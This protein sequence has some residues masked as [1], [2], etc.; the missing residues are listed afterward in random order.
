V[1][2]PLVREFSTGAGLANPWVLS[3][4]LILC[5]ITVPATDSNNH[6]VNGPGNGSEIIKCIYNHKASGPGTYSSD[7]SLRS[8][9]GTGTH[10]KESSFCSLDSGAGAHNHGFF[11]SSCAG[12]CTDCNKLQLRYVNS[13]DTYISERCFSLGS[14]R[15]GTGTG[16]HGKKFLIFSL[17]SGTGTHNH[18]FF[19]SSC[20]GASTECNNLQYR[21]VNITGTYITELCFDLGTSTGTHIQKL[22]CS[23]SVLDL[24]SCSSSGTCTGTNKKK[25]VFSLDSVNSALNSIIFFSC[26]SGACIYINKVQY[27]YANSSD[28]VTLVFPFSLGTGTGT[29]KQTFLFSSPAHNHRIFFSSGIG[30][31]DGAGTH[32]NKSRYQDINS[33]NTYILEVY[34]SLDTGTCMYIKKFF[35]S[36]EMGTV[37]NINI[38]LFSSCTGNGTH[39]H[40]FFFSYGNGTVTGAYSHINNL[41]YRY[42]NNSY[43]YKFVILS[44]SGTNTGTNLRIFFFSSDRDID[45]HISIVLFSSDTGTGAS[46]ETLILLTIHLYVSLSLL[47]HHFSFFYCLEMADTSAHLTD[48]DGETMEDDKGKVDETIL[49][50]EEEEQQDSIAPGQQEPMETTPPAT[51]ADG[52]ISGTPPAAATTVKP[53]GT[54]ASTDAT[55][56]G[57]NNTSTNNEP[58][59]VTDDKSRRGSEGSSSFATCNSGDNIMPRIYYNIRSAKLSKISVR[60]LSDCAEHN[61]VHIGSFEE[62]DSTDRA[63]IAN[64][65]HS[66][67]KLQNISSS[68]TLDTLECRSC[69]KGGH[70]VLHRESKTVDGRN[71][72]PQVFVL[73]DQNFP[74]AL[75]V[76]EDGECVKV[77]R[78]ENGSLHE[79]V[80]SFL[81][82]TKG[83]M[84]PAGTVVL[85]SSASLL[86]EVGVN[87]YVGRYL[88]ARNV[89]LGAFKGGLEVVHGLPIL[90]SG[91]SDRA[92]IRAL[93]DITDW[94]ASGPGTS[95]RDITDTRT[96]YKA[97]VLGTLA[98][99]GSPEASASTAGSSETPASGSG[100]PAAP[101]PIRYFLPT[102]LTGSKKMSFVSKPDNVPVIIV[103]IECDT[104]EL[105]LNTL[106]NELNAKFLADLAPLAVAE[107]DQDRGPVDPVPDIIA[108]G[109]KRFII[110]GGSHAARLAECLDNVGLHVA[111][112]SIPGWTVTDANVDSMLALLEKVLAEKSDKNSVIIYQLFDNDSYFGTNTDGSCLKPFKQGGKYHIQGDLQMADRDQLKVLVGRATPLLRAGGEADKIVLVP[113][114]RYVTAKCCSN[115]AH[116]TNFNDDS[117]GDLHANRLTEMRKWLGDICFFKRIRNFRV[118]C[119]NELLHECAGKAVQS[120]WAG[121]P[122]HMNNDGYRVLSVA[123]LEAL[124]DDL[125][126]RPY[127]EPQQATAAPPKRQSWVSRDDTIA[128]R[129]Y[130]TGHRPARGHGWSRGKPGVFGRGRR[131]GLNGGRGPRG[132]WQRP[133][134]Y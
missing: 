122:V 77:L 20:T 91:M 130:N 6:Y 19:F 3:P 57:G 60:N 15:S 42:S 72:I 93:V 85:L 84:V 40:R 54:T 69:I 133:K 86:A 27:R 73:S 113:L 5:S 88:S 34:L 66:Y 129:S 120:Y 67:T 17:D 32:I 99:A 7:L 11:F 23:F 76:E 31:I 51:A 70:P 56:E 125:P 58:K 24:I 4:L 28:T 131:G 25:L 18:K 52:T 81:E 78:I 87:E 38:F 47:A 8:G 63:S 44:S 134:P 49:D 100:S 104:E 13:N 89:L 102:D 105:L 115:P 50:N 74:A 96:M 65:R 39:V 43:T 83:F 109:D 10:E 118:W 26:C 128:G 95:T 106:L 29:H 124:K 30:T 114:V 98:M 36:S 117:W 61:T 121:N 46:E 2:R 94:F 71:L 107:P 64:Y 101:D 33:T 16:T 123:M 59:S 103:P 126:R 80:Q 111:D 127:T 110:I 55:T 62:N 41:R 53:G 12:A 116:I 132:R 112:L 9:I 21:Y 90:L 45:R 14:F 35:F 108:H 79:L 75:P 82:V 97:H 1:C 48:S 119:P 92:C 37:S 68:F 22:F